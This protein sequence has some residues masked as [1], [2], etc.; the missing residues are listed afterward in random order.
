VAFIGN[1]VILKADFIIQDEST[2]EEK[3]VDPTDIKLKVYE[4]NKKQIGSTID[5]SNVNK[6]DVGKYR[7][8]YVIPDGIRPIVYE[9]S[10]MYSGYP[11][12]GRGVFPR[13]W[14]K[15]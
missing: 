9:Y 8:N 4:D 14:V 3:Y 2:G 5:I 1:T 13:E 12:L 15:E 11:I 7:Y 6:K 10:G